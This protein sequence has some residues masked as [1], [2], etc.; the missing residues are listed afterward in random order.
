MNKFEIIK[1]VEEFLIKN[2]WKGV[3]EKGSEY[4]SFYKPG[5]FQIDVCRDEIVFIADEGDVYHLPI[6]EKNNI[7][8]Y[9]AMIGYMITN[10][11]IAMDFME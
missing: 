9:Y 11:L 5:N 4:F 8:I 10:R 3:N 6:Y 7:H 2:G 1:K